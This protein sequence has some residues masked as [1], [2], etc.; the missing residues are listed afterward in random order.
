MPNKYYQNFPMTNYKP[1][2]KIELRE[3]QF[4]LSTMPNNE[5]FSNMEISQD[6]QPTIFT[7]KAIVKEPSILGR[8][9]HNG[10]LLLMVNK[11]TFEQEIGFEPNMSFYINSKEPS[12]IS[13]ILTN[14]DNKHKIS[15]SEE[16]KIQSI[17]DYKKEIK[18]LIINSISILF[19][20]IVVLQ[21]IVVF[22]N[23]MKIRKNEFAMLQSIRNE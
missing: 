1:G 3:E 6:E 23:S 4:D 18:E 9:M 17:E 15:V 13:K 16:W 8:N 7:I 19:G 11:E 10:N 5:L 20:F 2:D 14:L 12:R 22:A 21:L